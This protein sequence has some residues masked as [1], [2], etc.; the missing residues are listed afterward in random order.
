MKIRNR[1]TLAFVLLSALLMLVVFVLIYY[2]SKRYTDRE[3]YL[4]L[5]QRA[6]IAAEAFLKED[7]VS[8]AIYNEIRTIHLQTLPN[9]VEYIYEVIPGTRSLKTEID[10]VYPPNFIGKIF[11]NEYAEAKIGDHHYA[12]ILYKDNHGDFIVVIAAEDLYGKEKM[13]NL[14]SVLFTTFVLSLAILFILGRYNAKQVLNPIARII[15]QVNKIRVTNL[16]LRLDPGN[17][18]DELAELAQTFNNML[19][20]LETSFEL[21]INFIN[22]ASHELRNPLT[23]IIGQTE[24]GLS[25]SRSNAEYVTTLESIEKEALRLDLLVNSLLRLA[26]TDYKQKGLLLEPIRMDEMLMDV[27]NSVDKINPDNHVTLDFSKLPHNPDILTVEGNY[28]LLNVALNNVVD[29]A[30]KFS[31]NNNVLMKITTTRDYCICIS[32]MDHGI[33]IPD[34][35]LKNVYE[36][37]FRGSNAE[38]MKGYG[39]GLPLVYKIIKMHRGSIQIKSRVNYGTEVVITLPAGRQSYFQYQNEF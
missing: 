35:D 10:V 8:A 16:H 25:R 18:K 23:A 20:R 31:E 15:K 34:E 9:E 13:R 33:G 30:C 24:V 2:F 7:E 32:V 19:D 3:F 21:Q 11:K 17:G 22:N 36:P 1:I 37:F 12:G 28:S 5:S 6:T 14:R 29:N 38:R 4:R 27:K 26:Q 39:F